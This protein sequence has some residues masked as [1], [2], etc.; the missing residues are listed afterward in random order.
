MLNL[1]L[2]T[3]L[4]PLPLNHWKTLKIFMATL[5]SAG[6]GVTDQIHF[7][8]LHSGEERP[9]PIGCIQGWQ[10]ETGGQFRPLKSPNTWLGIPKPRMLSVKLSIIAIICLLAFL[11]LHNLARNCR[12]FVKIMMIL[13][14]DNT[15]MEKI[16]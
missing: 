7:C 15:D 1:N 4:T 16:H 14:E 10:Q 9:F 5:G 11:Y 3:P 6:K 2:T 12:S 8:N 13:R